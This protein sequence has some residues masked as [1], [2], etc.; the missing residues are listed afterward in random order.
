MGWGRAG[1][2]VAG[3]VWYWSLRPSV[4]T[5]TMG[6]GIVSFAPHRFTPTRRHRHF[7]GLQ[8]LD[9]VGPAEVVF[10]GA[11]DLTAAW[12]EGEATNPAYEVEV[13]A[14]EA[15]P[16]TGRTSGYAIVPA[17]TID[18]CRGRSTP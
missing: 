1:E 8:P 17:K 9:V 18:R 3:I 13:V 16:L 15:G 2:G 7:S 11:S 10:A 14:E 4:D 12:V 6:H 5:G